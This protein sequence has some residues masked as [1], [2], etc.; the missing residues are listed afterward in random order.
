MR[1]RLLRGALLA[2]IAL[3]L[4]T[5]RVLWS[6]HGEWRE[7]ERCLAAN[8]PPAAVD[9]FGRAA[10]LYAPG[11]PW[12]ERSLGRL[13][14]IALGAEAHKDAPLALLAWR[15]LRSSVLATRSFYT[16]HPALLERTN[17][18]IARLMAQTEPPSVA[19]GA[20]LAARERWHA[21]RLAQDDAP[22]VL[23]SVLA[24][25]G[26]MGWIGAAI[27][28]LLRGIDNEARL[29]R[30]AAIGWGLGILAGLGLFLIALGRA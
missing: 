21:A 20:K 16:P 7:A 15:E 28:F 23:W 11:S 6:S 2:L 19:P 22:S 5:L 3:G 9:H 26:L 18:H 24:L 1:A 13:E 14:E 30:E 10:R 8:D 17:Q 27:G 12:V 29:R 4:M 25:V